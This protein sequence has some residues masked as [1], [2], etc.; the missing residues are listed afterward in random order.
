MVAMGKAYEKSACTRVVRRGSTLAAMAS[1]EDAGRIQRNSSTFLKSGASVRRVDSALH[2]LLNVDVVLDVFVG[3]VI[4]K[5]FQKL[6]E[7]FLRLGHT[8]ILLFPCRL[9]Y[10]FDRNTCVWAPS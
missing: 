7:L 3:D 8:R 10:R 4:R 6:Q 2:G 9:T 5:L 1:N